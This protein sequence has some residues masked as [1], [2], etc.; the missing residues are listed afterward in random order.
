[1]TSQTLIGR[2]PEVEAL[3][4]AVAAS[5]TGESRIVLVTGDAGIGKTR[6]VEELYAYVGELPELV[7]WRRGRSLAYGEGI[8]FWALGEVVKAQAGILESDSA[9]VADHKLRDAVESLG[10]EERDREWV[11]RHLGPLVGLEAATSRSDGSRV[12]GFAAWRRFLEALAAAGATVLVFEDIHWADDALL[13][14][15]DL[16]AERAGAVPML[17]VCTARPELFER[18]AGWAGGTTNPNTLMLTSLSE[19]DTARLVGD[20]LDQALLPAD[21]QQRLLTQAGGNPLYA[22]EYVRMLQDRSLL[23]HGETGWTL[24]G[25][26]EAPPESI[27]G[28]IAARLDT[29]SADEKSLLQDA[30]VIGRTAWLGA[31]CALTERNVWEADELLHGLER[32]QLVQRVRRSGAR[33]SSPSDTS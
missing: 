13:D 6:L 10:L 18:R 11:V 29:L 17:I 28:I 16:L 23:L 31:V 25:E 5:A 15:I 9:N 21:V 32:K 19:E 24:A 26:M 7:T 12:E 27:Q 2:A 20:L 14:F 4:A 3:H 30:A 22:Q 33:P 8:A 1:M